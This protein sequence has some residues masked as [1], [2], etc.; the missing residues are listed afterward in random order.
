MPAALNNNNMIIRL[1]THTQN[2][3]YQVQG[4]IFLKGELVFHLTNSLLQQQK[5]QQHNKHQAI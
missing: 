4:L 5:E 1:Q 2:Y 3:S